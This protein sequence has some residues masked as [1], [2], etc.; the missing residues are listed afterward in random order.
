MPITPRVTRLQPNE[1]LE[2]FEV[3]DASNTGEIRDI[4]ENVQDPGTQDKNYQITFQ[5]GDYSGI[6]GIQVEDWV[7]ITIL[8]GANFDSNAFTGSTENVVDLNRLAQ[9]GFDLDNLVLEGRLR[10]KNDDPLTGDTSTFDK[11]LQVGQDLSVGG[12]VSVTGEVTATDFT[13]SS[14]IRYKDNVTDI[15]STLSKVRRL[16]PKRYTWKHS[17]EEDVGLIAEEVADVF[18]ELVSRDENGRP[19]A[20]NY[21]KLSAVLVKAIQELL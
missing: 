11:N 14:S 13:E 21:S 3:Q 16:N 15:E 4:V 2:G 5:P 17:G 19:D 20:V 1:N 6:T 8:P 9:G 7:N 10:V 18:P 12:D